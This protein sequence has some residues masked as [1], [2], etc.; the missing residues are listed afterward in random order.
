[1]TSA[2]KFYDWSS[3]P[4]PRRLRL[5]IAEKGLTIDTEDVFVSPPDAICPNARPRANA[6]A[7]QTLTPASRGG[8]GAQ[9]KSVPGLS[10]SFKE[11]YPRATTPALELDDGTIIG[12]AAACMRYLE[13]VRF[14]PLLALRHISLT[15]N[16]SH[17]FPQ[18][19][20]EPPLFGSTPAQK[21]LVDMWEHSAYEDGLMAAAETFRNSDAS[22]SLTPSPV[23][24]MF[25]HSFLL[26]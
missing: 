2:V 21:A 13:S 3:A 22:P 11:K 12:D 25:P 17:I 14:N 23:V 26:T 8:D 19:H 9:D 7:A 15:F 6:S 18:I 1:M 20:P 4:N 16:F 10:A 24:R 5:F